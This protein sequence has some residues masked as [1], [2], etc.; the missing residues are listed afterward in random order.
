MKKTVAIVL[1]V[2]VLSV[3]AYDV[4]YLMNRGKKTTSGAAAA[5][6]PAAVAPD[7]SGGSS[8]GTPASATEAPAAAENTD[9][10]MALAKAAFGDYTDDAAG[11]AA[12]EDPFSE[13]NAHRN[14]PEP[15]VE[16]SY[17]PEEDAPIVTISGIICSQRPLAI[18]N[19]RV[20]GVGDSIGGGWTVLRIER[21]CIVVQLD[22]R[23]FKL[24]TGGLEPLEVEE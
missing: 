18:V 3:V 11:P 19:E 8:A 4:H 15:S 22:G 16:P 24:F 2:L 10:L 7:A 12:L 23:K 9:D 5:D 20:V 1:G 6:E 17:E 14:T 21:R 13:G